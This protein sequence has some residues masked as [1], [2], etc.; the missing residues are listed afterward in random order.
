MKRKKKL[1]FNLIIIQKEKM[2]FFQSWDFFAVV[3]VLEVKHKLVNSYTDI[4]ILTV[5]LYESII[6][7]VYRF[8]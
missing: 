8:R 1:L 7:D 2:S 6:D 4:D 3:N 5:N